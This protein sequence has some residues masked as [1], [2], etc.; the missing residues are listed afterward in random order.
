MKD[1][2]I[3]LQI[4]QFCSTLVLYYYTKVKFTTDHEISKTD[5]SFEIVRS[6]EMGE[7]ALMFFNKGKRK[8]S[9]IYL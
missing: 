5:E 2:H 1:F 7:M 9:F 4:N 3:N 8:T 6:I